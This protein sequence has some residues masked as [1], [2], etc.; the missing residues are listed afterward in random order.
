MDKLTISEWLFNA[1]IWLTFLFLNRHQ[2]YIKSNKGIGFVPFLI[3]VVL[4]STFG[5]VSGDYFHYKGLY[6]DLLF[7]SENV[8]L[9]Q[10]YYWLIKNFPASYTLWRF[11]IW[12]I[13]TIV[14]VFILKRLKLNPYFS[15]LIFALLLMLYFP[16][17]RNTL[18]YVIFYWGITFFFLKWRNLFISF[19]LGIIFILC[20]YFLHK[21][22]F[23]YIGL[24]II[25]ILI[26]WNKWIYI[27]SL[28]L[29]PFLYKSL[30]L[31]A[32][33]FLIYSFVDEQSVDAG[34]R[35]LESD[36][37][38]VANL[39]GLIQLALNRFPIIVLMIYSIYH[40]Y[41]RSHN[42]QS[43]F[44]FFLNYTYVLM[45]ISFLF[46]GQQVSAFL[47]PRFWDA[48]MYTATLFFSYY[49]YVQNRTPLIKG[50]LNVLILANVYNLVYILYKL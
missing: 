38:Q 11:V 19:M 42:I 40:I 26:R 28:I 7:S 6:N 17:P 9:E 29:F 36:F 8:H 20:S 41:F 5:F 21:S 50:S 33:Y 34:F 24:F 31:F 22:M 13:S 48:S 2:I 32:E 46:Y 30:S 16:N 44:R 1:I 45:Y 47:S 23:V 3:I 35:Y 10:F 27:A 49:L 12:G 25:I 14:F 4:F 15:G 39:N 43:V 37:Y 18:A